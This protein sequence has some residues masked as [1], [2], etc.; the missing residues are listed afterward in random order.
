[1]SSS[2]S[3]IAGVARPT[4]SRKFGGGRVAAII[5]A[6]LLTL[7]ALA[8]LV[9]GI[10]AVVADRTARG[11]DGFISTDTTRYST[12]TYALLSD[13]FSGGTAGDWV[14]PADV[15]GEVRLRAT[16][17][18]PIFIGIGRAAA[19]DRYLDA[20]RRE[21]VT[22]LGAA[23]VIGGHHDSRVIAGGIPQLRPTQVKI[24]TVAARGSGTQT[25]HWK[26]HK[27]DWRVVV[28]N[29]DASKGVAFD[30]SVGAKFPHLLAIGIGVAG[31][32]TVVLA[33]AGLGLYLALRRPRQE[34]RP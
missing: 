9:G 31:G 2:I 14:T 16:G 28:M 29:P 23:D 10:A 7:I 4:Q 32:S 12:L 24:W 20:V 6:S 15:L 11:S 18:G 5:V 25:L 26:A 30:L 34:A 19:V 27:G 1:M 33:L 13:R 8:G 22:N 21:E 17:S 3:P